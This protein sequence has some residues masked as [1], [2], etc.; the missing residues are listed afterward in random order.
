[1]RLARD[2]Q[3]FVQSPAG[4][5]ITKLACC[6]PGRYQEESDWALDARTGRVIPLPHFNA[7]QIGFLTGYLYW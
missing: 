7:G 2:R 5:R 4:V 6:R 3:S 1:V